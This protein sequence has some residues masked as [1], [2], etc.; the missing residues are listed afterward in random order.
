[1]LL[2]TI[3]GNGNSWE[4]NAALKKLAQIKPPDAQQR[5][6]VAPVLEQLVASDASFVADDA[7]EALATWWRPQT[8]DVLLPLMDEKEWVGWKRGR[9]MKVLARTGDKRAATPIMRWLLKDA[10]NVVAA[11]IELGPVAE[12][13]AIARLREKE[14]TARAGAARILSAVGT[15]KCLIELRR[16]AN[17]PRDAGAA[18]T[19]RSALETVLA[20]VKQTKAATT[21]TAPAR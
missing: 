13:E 2:E 17:D 19:A 18:A 8:V 10:E 14:P 7:A 6:T 15:S 3:Q 11:M 4:K 20:R 1:M 12:D 21:T 16:A 9:A 5:D